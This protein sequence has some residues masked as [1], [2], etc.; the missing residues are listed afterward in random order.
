MSNKV[1]IGVGV[2]VL[3]ALLFDQ[4]SNSGAGTLFLARK[5]VEL[6]EWMAFWR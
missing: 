4:F 5:F 3:L 2:A 6:T 1:A